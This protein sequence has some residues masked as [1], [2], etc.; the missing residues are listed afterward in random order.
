MRL[1]NPEMSLEAQTVQLQDKIAFLV[2]EIL[3]TN[4]NLG[5]ALISRCI[6]KICLKASPTTPI[7]KIPVAIV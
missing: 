6:E 3:A 7:Y 4:I 1:W 5:R 2:V